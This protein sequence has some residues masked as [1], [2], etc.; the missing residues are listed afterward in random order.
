M[1]Y[2]SIDCPKCG[3]VNALERIIVRLWL[4]NKCKR[5]GLTLRTLDNAKISWSLR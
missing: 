1:S 2:I 4:V 3:F 5:C